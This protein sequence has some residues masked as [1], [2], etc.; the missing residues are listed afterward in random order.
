MRFSPQAAFFLSLIAIVAAAGHSAVCGNR[1]YS[2]DAV[3]KASDASCSYVKNGT[4]V[5]TNMYPHQY[6]NLEKLNLGGLSGPFYE[7][8]I[9]SNG[10]VYFSGNPGPDRVIITRDCKLAGVITHQGANGNGFLECN[11]KT[12]AASAVAAAYGFLFALCL[13][14]ALLVI[15][16]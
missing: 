15:A 16:V 7:F 14:T 10:Q 6:K 9:L 4:S 5:G 1:Q 11:V 12:S 3:A 13:P 2:T 8:P